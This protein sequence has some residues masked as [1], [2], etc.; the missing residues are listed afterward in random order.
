MNLIRV[1]AQAGN[2][3]LAGNFPNLDC[4]AMIVYCDAAPIRTESEVI[5]LIVPDITTLA[6]T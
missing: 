4:T 3:G 5:Y 1:P 6:T 2:N